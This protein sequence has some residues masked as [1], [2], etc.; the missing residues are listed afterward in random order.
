MKTFQYAIADTFLCALINGDTTGLDD[1]D[2]QYLDDFQAHVIESHGVGHW[3]VIS[4]Y[5][6]FARDEVT[7]LHANCLTVEWVVIS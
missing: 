3:S 2:E 1:S 6:E 5:A 7:G 4:D